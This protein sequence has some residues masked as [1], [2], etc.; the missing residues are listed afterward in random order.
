M[1]STDVSYIEFFLRSDVS[2][3]NR[4]KHYFLDYNK[5]TKKVSISL[6]TFERTLYS[7]LEDIEEMKLTAQ[8]GILKN[9]P[10]IDRWQELMKSEPQIFTREKAR[11]RSYSE[12]IK[13]FDIRN[14][15]SKLMVASVSIYPLSSRPILSLSH[16]DAL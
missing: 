11:S 10:T 13:I 6:K 12:T 2:S 14:T 1:F 8:V 7:Y 4:Y 5:Q 3:F 9:A 15:Y 16:L